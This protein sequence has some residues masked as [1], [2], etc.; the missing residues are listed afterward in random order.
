[1][2][3]GNEIKDETTPNLHALLN[4][5]FPDTNTYKKF[6]DSLISFAKSK[7]KIFIT[8]PIYTLNFPRKIL[9][10]I[11][12]IKKYNKETLL[13]EMEKNNLGKSIKNPE[14]NNEMKYV[15]YSL[16]QEQENNER[17][18]KLEFFNNANGT[19]HLKIYSDQKKDILDLT[20]NNSIR[21]SYGEKENYINI[22]LPTN[23]QLNQWKIIKKILLYEDIYTEEQQSSL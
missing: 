5:L 8:N 14:E 17:R 6:C 20:K 1:M 23:Q 21:Y 13:G 7:S 15:F 10:F 19:P 3:T 16:T 12:D 4:D 18:T 9:S 2:T 22:E 11:T